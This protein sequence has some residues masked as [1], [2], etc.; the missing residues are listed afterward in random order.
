[1][2]L[3]ESVMIRPSTA[4]RSGRHHFL[5]STLQ[6]QHFP[7]LPRDW[8]QCLIKALSYTCKQQLTKHKKQITPWVPPSD[9][10]QGEAIEF[11]QFAGI[12]FYRQIPDGFS[13]FEGLVTNKLPLVL[14][15]PLQTVVIWVTVWVSG[16]SWKCRP[17][18]DRQNKR[19][20]PEILRFQDVYG[21]GGRTRTYDLRVMSGD[22]L[23][24]FNLKIRVYLRVI[25]N[26]RTYLSSN[27]IRFPQFQVPLPQIFPKDF[28]QK[29]PHVSPL[30]TLF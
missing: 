19:K 24:F 26:K 27:Q 28:C 6:R 13:I 21:C 23:N 20:S 5:G 17:T 2:V 15:C 8:P 14:P 22:I 16:V 9:S 10:T 30:T 18:F 11:A 4:F 29:V 25:K 7:R 1:M 12:K 3:A